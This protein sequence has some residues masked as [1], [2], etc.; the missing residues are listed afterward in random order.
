MTLKKTIAVLAVALAL[1]GVSVA[2]EHPEVTGTW[3]LDAAKSDFGPAPVPTDLVVTIT[4][5]APD[6]QIHQ[7]GAGQPDMDLKFSTSGQPVTNQVGGAKM[8]ST[9]RWEG[10]VITGEVA[11]DTPDGTRITF[12]DRITYSPDGKVMTTER[13]INSPMGEGRMKMVMNRK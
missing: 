13:T 2:A 3:A 1:A 12:K 8:T 5:K 4:G 6:Y 11:L 7:T 10:D 9:H